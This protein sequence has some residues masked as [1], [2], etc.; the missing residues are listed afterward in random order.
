MADCISGC[1]GALTPLGTVEEN[2]VNTMA[3]I[4]NA[5]IPLMYFTEKRGLGAATF[6]FDRKEMVDPVNGQVTRTYT[7]KS[8]IGSDSKFQSV[9]TNADCQ[10]VWREQFLS[11]ASTTVAAD[12]TASNTFTVTSIA[13]L[14]GIGAGAKIEVYHAGRLLSLGVQS[15]L[16]NVITL[17]PWV[18]VT[19]TAGDCVYRGAYNRSKE[20]D[21]KISNK[22]ELTGYHSKISNFRN[23]SLSLEFKT[24]DLSVDRFV[25][26]LGE[27]GSQKF[28]NEYKQAAVEGFVNELRSIFYTDRNLKDGVD[29]DGNTVAAA[30][31]NET[32]GLLSEISRVQT[33][34]D[35]DLIVDISGC[36]TGT[37]CAAGDVAVIKSF[38]EV[39]RQ[40]HRSGLY[41]NNVLTL[42]ANNQFLENMQRMQSAFYDVTGLT[43]NY[44]VPTGGEYMVRQA[45]PMIQ[46]GDIKVERM[47]DDRLDKYAEPLAIVLP[48]EHV[49]FA[50][51]KYHALGSDMNVTQEINY[52][53][54]TGFPRLKFKDRTEYETN[55]L[56]DC[57]VYVS[58]MEFAT[59]FAGVETGAYRII[60]W[61]KSCD[62]ICGSCES[63]TSLRA[64]V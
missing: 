22:Y 28:I 49:Y 61:F 18:T 31:T 50:Q 3:P 21:A 42:V 24:C 39:L 25:N 2:I 9:M 62:D 12:V 23:I 38:F 34:L 41:R 6:M 57:F 59:V 13:K 60:K 45:Y 33:A 63:A 51:K 44:D 37:A 40:A 17:Q 48:K 30:G 55:G 11:I 58:D 7:M 52:N 32:M 14:R 20:C 27:N 4:V 19:L 47:Y 53:I 26:Y 35:K 43:I 29:V 15:I 56:G 36:C 10:L 64:T 8:G 1:A 5:G 54:Q 16:G 46:L